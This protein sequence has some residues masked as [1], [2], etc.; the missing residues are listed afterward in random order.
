MKTALE[1]DDG[2]NTGR[3]MG[4]GWK[5]VYLSQKVHTAIMKKTVNCGISEGSGK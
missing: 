3:K 5:S 4:I 1:S 2:A